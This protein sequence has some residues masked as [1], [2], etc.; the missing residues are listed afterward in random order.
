VLVGQSFTVTVS[1][2]TPGAFIDLMIDGSSQ[3][4][5]VADQAGIARI[6]TVLYPTGTLSL[7]VGETT[8]Q[9]GTPVKR[10]AMGVIV[11][12]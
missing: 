10:S 9:N 3:G 6:V 2:A 7:V 11:V 12:S 8:Y 5:A 4:G 1:N